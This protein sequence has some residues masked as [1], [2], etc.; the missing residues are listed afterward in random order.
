MTELISG[1]LLIIG[2]LLMLLAGIGLL[3]LPDFLCRSHAVAKGMTLGIVLILISSGIQMDTSSARIKI[4]LAVLF[5][6]ITIPVAGH[7]LGMVAFRKNIPRWK[8]RPLDDH[9]NPHGRS[10]P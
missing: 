10:A 5:Q 2:S 8:E 6:L 4:A 9:R 1:I 3:V 7:L